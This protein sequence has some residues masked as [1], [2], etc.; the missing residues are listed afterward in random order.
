MS[1]KQELKRVTADRLQAAVQD[2]NAESRFPESA[3]RETLRRA[4]EYAAFSEVVRT[5]QD[6]ARQCGVDSPQVARA[7][8]MKIIFEALISV[9]E[10]NEAD[11]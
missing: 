6:I 2:L 5:V 11:V 4:E 10:G 7:E 8:G 9:A 3:V 1:L